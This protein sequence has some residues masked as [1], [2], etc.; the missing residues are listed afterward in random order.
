MNARPWPHSIALCCFLGCFACDQRPTD[1]RE[2]RPADHTN[3]ENPQQQART[4]QVTGEAKDV[5]AGLDD[6]TVVTWSR[7]CASCHGRTG[8]GDGPQGRM[9]NPRPRDLTQAEW[10]KAVTDEYIA[11]VIT[12]GRNAMPAFNLPE[13]TVTALVQLIRLMGQQAEAASATE[14][15]ASATE[16]KA[17]ESE[18]ESASGGGA[19]TASG[20]KPKPPRPPPPKPRAPTAVKPAN[21]TSP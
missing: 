2:W 16:D 8:R 19:P 17:T 3:V 4:G 18:S 7:N 6:V 1:V 20:G 13:G 12:K 15:S 9:L 10:Q 21:S 5:P 14:Q 11:T